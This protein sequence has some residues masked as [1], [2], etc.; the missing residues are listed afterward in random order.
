VS[1][2]AIRGSLVFPVATMLALG[3]V[4]VS[5]TPGSEASLP[6]LTE[7]SAVRLQAEVRSL[8]NGMAGALSAEPS[9]EPSP[10]AAANSPIES[11][12][13]TAAADSCIYPCTFFDKFLS[14]LPEDVRYAILPAVYVVA[15][16]VGLII[17]PV[18][19]VTSALFGW[20]TTLP[21]AAAATPETSPE[22]AEAA[23]S[24]SDPITSEPDQEALPPGPAGNAAA[25]EAVGIPTGNDDNRSR[26]S[27]QRAT[28]AG[29]NPAESSV[30]P[31]AFAPA[32][33]ATE[34][35]TEPTPSAEVLTAAI[36]AA[37]EAAPIR[38][39]PTPARGSLEAGTTEAGLA[40]A[41]PA[42]A[43]PADSA[44]APQRAAKRSV[45]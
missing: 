5:H 44:R 20:P 6:R 13:G 26:A 34:V 37:E 19:L 41:G 28:E 40:E 15:W 1:S 31:E 25:D 16:W 11:A 42:E 39:R 23:A 17:A 12:T 24:A 22:P 43:G 45:R 9:A 14:S 7:V 21:G 18:V 10:A 29:E 36:T 38:D 8:V 4:S 35:A 32:T 2:H 3:L 33:T 27:A 30:S